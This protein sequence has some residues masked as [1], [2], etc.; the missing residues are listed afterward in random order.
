MPTIVR[1]ARP[2]NYCIP[3]LLP[4]FPVGERGYCANDWCRPQSLP[5][6]RG[7]LWPPPVRVCL[8]VA[9]PAERGIRVSRTCRCVGRTVGLH[10]EV[11][12]KVEWRK[13]R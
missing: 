11:I 8:Q 5:R 1:K 12:K 4:N 3:I 10:S 13:G 7:R 9:R 2:E 6:V